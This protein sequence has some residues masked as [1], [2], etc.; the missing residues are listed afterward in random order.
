MPLP[1]FSQKICVATHQAI[2]P[3]SI[4]FLEHLIGVH[5]NA[6]CALWLLILETDFDKLQPPVRIVVIRYK[7]RGLH[8]AQKILF[9]LHKRWSALKRPTDDQ[10]DP[11]NA[12]FHVD[13]LH[14]LAI[15]AAGPG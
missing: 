8:R 5:Y 1:L 13:T 9:L 2:F 15:G 11:G 10:P 4:V 7:R 14:V 6:S 12:L 3:L